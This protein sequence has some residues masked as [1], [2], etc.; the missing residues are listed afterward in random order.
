MTVVKLNIT[1]LCSFFFKYNLFLMG[2]ITG[3]LLYTLQR[4]I[5]PTSPWFKETNPVQWWILS[6]SSRNVFIC[7][8]RCRK[9][10]FIYSV[11]MVPQ[12]TLWLEVR[13]DVKAINP[14]LPSLKKTPKQPPKKKKKMVKTA[15]TMETSLQAGRPNIGKTWSRTV[16]QI[17][18]H[19]VVNV[20]WVSDPFQGRV[21]TVTQP[22]SLSCALHP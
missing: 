21:H 22:V 9:D 16:N 19:E 11:V 17:Y 10:G 13:V 14:S 3:R 18:T 2:L 6:S 12:N 15:F 7:R 1:P 20:T 4:A 5:W 8:Q